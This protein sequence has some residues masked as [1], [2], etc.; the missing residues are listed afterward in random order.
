MYEYGLRQENCTS[1]ATMVIDYA[2]CSFILL[3]FPQKLVFHE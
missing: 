1:S 3:Q 2:L